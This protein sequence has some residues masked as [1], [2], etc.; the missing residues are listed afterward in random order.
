MNIDEMFRRW[1]MFKYRYRNVDEFAK[2]YIGKT[3]E[4]L[5]HDSGRL[6]NNSEQYKHEYKM[7]INNEQ[8]LIRYDEDTDI[9]TEINVIRKIETIDSCYKSNAPRLCK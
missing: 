4:E 3:T 1:N 7:I 2:A 5:Y 6:P 9:I 8:C